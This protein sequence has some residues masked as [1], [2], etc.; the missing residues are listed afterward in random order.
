[1]STVKAPSAATT[2]QVALL[3]FGER[4]F[5]PTVLHRIEGWNHDKGLLY[6][7][8]RLPTEVDSRTRSLNTYRQFKA[9][10]LRT[11]GDLA[12]E[13]RHEWSMLDR[14]SSEGRDAEIYRIVGGRRQIFNAV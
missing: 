3:R 7:R 6:E 2:Q 10:L 8:F 13:D 11:S 12:R 5:I 1:M 14:R 4:P 9:D